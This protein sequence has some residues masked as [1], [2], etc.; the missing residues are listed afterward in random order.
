MRTDRQTDRQTDGHDEGNMCFL[1]TV[2]N[3]IIMLFCVHVCIKCQRV[4]NLL[5]FAYLLRSRKNRR[6]EHVATPV[7]NKKFVR[8]V[9]LNF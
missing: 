6:Q 7:R 4:F 5:C 2:L 1:A 8:N 3:R 9:G